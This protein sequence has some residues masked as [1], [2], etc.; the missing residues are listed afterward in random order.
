MPRV[1]PV[2]IAA[3][4]LLGWLGHAAAQAPPGALTGD[5]W[6]VRPALFERGV[7][8]DTV[9]IAEGFATLDG[10]VRRDA[11]FLDAVDF[12]LTLDGERLFGWPGL[13]V[14]ADVLGTHGGHPSAFVGDAQGVSEIAGPSR[15]RLQE[16][17]VQQSLLGGRVSLLAG[18]YDLGTE[19][20]LLPAAAV[21]I[22]SSFGAG[23]EFTESGRHGPSVF[24]DT[25]VGG[26]LEVRPLAALV[27]RTAVFSGFVIGEIAWMSD[28]GKVAIGGWAYTGT[29]DDLSRVERDGSPVRHHGS[30]GA[31]LIGEQTIHQLGGD[32]ARRVTIFGQLGIGDPRVSRYAAYTGAGLVVVGPWA[33]R[34]QDQVALGVA[35]AH[36]GDQYLQQQRREG[37]RAERSE[38]TVELTY[39]AQ[40]A[41]WLFVQPDFQYVIN[42]NTDPARAN[43]VVGGVRLTGAF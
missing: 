20:Y 18:R 9:V 4:I 33:A 29:L 2:V 21:L 24:P 3:I 15:W 42:P 5:W 14:L 22:N 16:G 37:L 10:G 6:G 25:T 23:P 26:R 34:G 32:P 43:A 38:V 17:W 31:Y 39:R 1:R 19:F 11:T 13:T 8:I 7:R 27:L 36:N 12:R 40:V 28:E 30:A 35:A 41:P